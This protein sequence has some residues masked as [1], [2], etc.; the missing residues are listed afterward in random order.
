MHHILSLSWNLFC[1]S[2][3]MDSMRV[4]VARR[5]SSN[6]LLKRF[7]RAISGIISSIFWC[8]FLCAQKQALPGLSARV[9]DLEIKGVLTTHFGWLI[10][11]T[12]IQILP[13]L[14]AGFSVSKNTLFLRHAFRVSKQ[15]A[16]ST[17]TNQYISYIK[18]A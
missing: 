16:Y 4:F 3:Y 17:I 12:Q 9:M 7:I 18:N 1:I 13:G 5:I 14:C 10:L 6:K 15:G 11:R 2:C 8:G